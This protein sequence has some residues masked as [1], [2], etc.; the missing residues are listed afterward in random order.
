LHRGRLADANKV[1]V[2]DFATHQ[3]LPAGVFERAFANVR[4]PNRAARS[5]RSRHLTKN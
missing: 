3:H 4:R 5:A 2:L 1:T